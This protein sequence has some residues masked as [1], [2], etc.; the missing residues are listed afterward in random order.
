MFNGMLKGG[1][2]HT[3]LKD[4][5]LTATMLRPHDNHNAREEV[6]RSNRNYNRGRGTGSHTITMVIENWDGGCIIIALLRTTNC[7]RM[8]KFYAARKE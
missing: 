7:S 6:R 1:P 2:V 3:I 5:H 8:I 4:E